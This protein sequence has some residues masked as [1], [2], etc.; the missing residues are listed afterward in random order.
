M[1]E[2]P[3]RCSHQTFPDIY[4]F[5]HY[6]GTKLVVVKSKTPKPKKTDSKRKTSEQIFP[7]FS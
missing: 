3:L 2:C 5:C 4:N 7:E 6:C 1:K